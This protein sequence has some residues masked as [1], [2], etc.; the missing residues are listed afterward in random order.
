MAAQ[1]HAG[2][3]PSGDRRTTR[4]CGVR[5]EERRE[6]VTKVSDIDGR[7][8]CGLMCKLSVTLGGGDAL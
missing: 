4:I 3:D 7:S 8:G 2:A 6:E 5:E 1:A